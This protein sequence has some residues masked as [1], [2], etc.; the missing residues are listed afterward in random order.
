MTDPVLTEFR[1]GVA[2]ITL[3]RPEARNAANLALAEGLAAAVDELDARPDIS[4]AI[5]T[6]AGGNFCSGMD[7]KAFLRGERGSVPGR[8][9]AG[10]TARPPSTPIIAAVEGAAVAGGCELVLA[11][12]MIVAAENA[13]FGVPEVKRGLVAVGGA[14]L[15]LPS[16]IPHQIAM[17]LILT[18]DLID[19]RRAHELGL[20]NR[21]TPA[22]GALQ[23]A[24]ELAASVAVNGPLAVRASK[25]IVLAAPSWPVDQAYDLQMEI[26][27]PAFESEDAQEGARAFAEKRAPR[28]TGR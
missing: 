5:L 3:N 15:R 1:D 25:E 10:V 17:E 16:R 6:G 27:K 7:L 2:V 8:G 28:W 26:A 9:F 24:E 12:D 13:R 20:V 18:G 4:V 23:G 22:G 21:L 11:C 19:G 14:L